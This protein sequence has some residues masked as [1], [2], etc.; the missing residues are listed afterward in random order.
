MKFLWLLLLIPGALPA[1]VPN[2][3]TL[4]RYAQ[5]WTDSPFTSKP[6]QTINERQIDNPL[7]DFTLG[8]IS[9]L[10]DGY[11]AVLINKKKPDERV[12]IKPGGKSD[13]QVVSVD[14]SESNWKDT[15]ATVRSGSFQGQV[16]FDEQVLKTTKTPPRQ[17][18][19]KPNL[20]QTP[21]IPGL[22]QNNANRKPQVR[23]PR[24]RVVRPPTPAVNK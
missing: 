4:S 17:Q 23:K 10:K 14:W 20:P 21:N 13:Y 7:D 24:P 2:K 12:V 18:A 1:E 11:Y 5:L 22:N 3:P 15:V 6:V 19:A 9:K 8:G 16:G